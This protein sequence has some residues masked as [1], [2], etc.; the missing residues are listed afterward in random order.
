MKQNLFLG[1]TLLFVTYLLPTYALASNNAAAVS[2]DPTIFITAI[3][4]ASIDVTQSNLA[5]NTELYLETNTPSQT[6]YKLGIIK[7]ENAKQS[8][9]LPAL[10]YG[11]MYVIVARDKSGNPLTQ[12]ETVQV[13]GFAKDAPACNIN[14]SKNVVAPDEVFKLTWSSPEA[15]SVYKSVGFSDRPQKSLKKKGEIKLSSSIPGI[16]Q[17]ALVFNAESGNQSVCVAF[18]EVVSSVD[19]SAKGSLVID[20][21]PL[22]TTSVR[23]IITGSAQGAKTVKVMVSLPNEKAG[24]LVWVSKP[25]TVKNGKWSTKVG[26]LPK[27]NTEYTVEVYV[28]D[29]GQYG[30]SERA[31][32]SVK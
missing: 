1:V 23:P 17:Y 28:Y 11:G 4:S 16:R 18:V 24:G 2:A 3:N 14:S 12:S 19:R 27:R 30:S 13:G 9:K 7:G 26:K 10:Q 29:D 32:L 25:I 5:A 20:V 6:S 15:K 8:F 22:D 31:T 21:V